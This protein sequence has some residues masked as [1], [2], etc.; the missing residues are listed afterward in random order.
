MNGVIGMTELAL[1]TDPASGEHRE[2]L[3]TVKVS[4]LALLTVINDILDFS[5]IEAGKLDLDLV[6]FRLRDCLADALRSCA[7][8]A[9]EKGLELAQQ[10]AEDVPDYLMGDP[11]RLRQ[12]MLNLLGNAIKF[13]QQGQIQMCVSMPRPQTLT[14]EIID[15]GPGIPAEQLPDIFEPFRRGSNYAQREQQGAGLGLSITRQIVT[16]MGGQISAAST[17]GVGST[18]TVSLPLEPVPG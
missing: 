7:V 8:R 2:Y 14:I 6:P 9:H 16:Q 10:V 11:G 18:F 3:E 15:S 1:Q 12:I 4:G 13:T 5:K 17:P